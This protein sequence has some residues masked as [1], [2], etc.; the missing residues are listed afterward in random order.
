MLSKEFLENLFN[1][2]LK[3]KL[4]FLEKRN[5]NESTC[6]TVLSTNMKSIESNY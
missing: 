6:L 4:E 2:Q 3:E 1:K 5:S